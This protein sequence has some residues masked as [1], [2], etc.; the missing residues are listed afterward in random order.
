MTLVRSHVLPS[1]ATIVAPETC[2]NTKFRRGLKP[3]LP[4]GV[5]PRR[6]QQT[7]AGSRSDFCD[8]ECLAGRGTEHAVA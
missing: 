6:S 4:K 5:Q 1:Q 3:G 2:R 7:L 8:G